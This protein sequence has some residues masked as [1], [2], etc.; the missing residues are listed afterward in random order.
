MNK[1]QKMYVA[2]KTARADEEAMSNNTNR[3]T[4][5]EEMTIP[6]KKKKKKVGVE[7][8]ESNHSNICVSSMSF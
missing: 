8:G 2:N 1:A 6:R 7:E 5:G 3:K 4:S